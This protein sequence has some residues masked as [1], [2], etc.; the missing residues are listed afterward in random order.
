[1]SLTQPLHLTQ[2]LTHNE[3]LEQNVK[4]TNKQNYKTSRRNF[5]KNLL[6]WV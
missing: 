3:I 2:K 1:M 5:G 6:P 4:Q